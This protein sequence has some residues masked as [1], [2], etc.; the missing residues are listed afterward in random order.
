[1]ITSALASTGS[2]HPLSSYL[3]LTRRKSKDSLSLTL[4]VFLLP[5][6]SMWIGYFLR[7]LSPLQTYPLPATHGR[8]E[9]GSETLTQEDYSRMFPFLE[10]PLRKSN[11]RIARYDRI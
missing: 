10:P 3:S 8:N 6:F 7:L 4:L 2:Y 5:G 9:D 1:M 11:F